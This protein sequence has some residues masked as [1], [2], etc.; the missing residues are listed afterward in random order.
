MCRKVLVALLTLFL[1]FFAIC[2]YLITRPNPVPIRAKPASAQE[3]V[4]AKQHLAA[5]FAPI[6]PTKPISSTPRAEGTAAAQTLSEGLVTIHIRSD[7]VNTLLTTDRKLRDRMAA[8][9]ITSAQ[10]SFSEP[11]IVEGFARMGIQGSEQD[12]TLL[13]TLV[14]DGSGGAT[15]VPSSI[16]IGSLPVPESTVDDKLRKFT[17]QVIQLGLKHLPISIQQIKVVNN[18][19][20]LTGPP[21][22]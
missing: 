19:L 22:I 21:K 15:F 1:L 16:V 20:D 17:A 12:V 3:V 13:G 4:A 9:G 6:S 8:E 18:E 7:D 5:A 11:N 10:V 14:T 2:I